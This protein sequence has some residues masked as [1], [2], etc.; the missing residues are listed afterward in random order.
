LKPLLVFAIAFAALLSGCSGG[1]GATPQ[2]AA[3]HV[4]PSTAASGIASAGITEAQSDAL[5]V[6]QTP[7]AFA[8]TDMLYVSNTGTNTITVY[9]HDQQGNTAPQWV[10][11]G[12][13]TGID[14]PGS[15]AEDSYGNLYVANGNWQA[16]GS[17][18]SILVFA[19]HAKGNV[20][21]IRI[22][23]GPNSGLKYIAAMTVDLATNKI[24]VVDQVHSDALYLFFGVGLSRFPPGAGW[25]TA[26]F[27]KSSV[28]AGQ[29]PAIELANDS[30]GNNLLEVYY[31][32]EPEP[33]DQ[34]MGTVPKQ[35]SN[36]TPDTWLIDIAGEL[37]YGVADDPSTKTYLVTQGNRIER[38]AETANYTYDAY[39]NPI[40]PTPVSTITIS[41]SCAGGMLAL[42]YL[43]NIYVVHSKTFFRCNSDAVYVYN[44]DASG[45]ATPLRILSGST[46]QLNSPMGIYEGK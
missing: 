20:A 12:S 44:H 32:A 6:R 29:E 13:K 3:S 14:T 10:I 37:V 4:G 27:A 15:L 24:F 45:A 25:N 7:A 34:G 9:K 43:R 8:T 46:T 33:R 21:P 28:S 39:Q 22:I 40:P 16:T 1:G 23:G 26:P 11:G 2:T 42:G 30:T 18:P 41:N 19:P 35:F 31:A 5:N 36:N 17:H 38:Y